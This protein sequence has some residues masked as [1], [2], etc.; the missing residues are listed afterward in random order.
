MLK[1]KRAGAVL[2]AGMM[3]VSMT[4]CGGDDSDSAESTTGA[5]VGN[6]TDSVEEGVSVPDNFENM[7][8]AM[9]ALAMENYYQGYPY[10]V[11]FADGSSR[12]S[13]WYSCALTSKLLNE[14]EDEGTI[15]VDDETMNQIVSGLYAS[16]QKGDLEFPEIRDGIAYAKY[17]DDGT[18]YV[19]SNSASDYVAGESS[20][21]QFSL[22]VT[23]CEATE[24]GYTLEA[25]LEDTDVGDNLGT[26]VF[27]ME[28]TQYSGGNSNPFAYSISSMY[29]ANDASAV[30]EETSDATEAGGDIESTDESADT[31]ETSESVDSSE[32]TEGDDA[33]QSDGSGTVTQDEALSMAQE[34]YGNEN[35]YTYQGVVYIDAYPYYSFTVESESLSISYVLVSESGTDVV[36]ANKNSDG[37]WSF[38]Q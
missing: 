26:Y 37:T 27:T 34:T 31:T 18:G 15:S 17:S 19:F 13:F 33:A 28:E 7:L 14:D 1:L 36:G 6:E 32:E 38:D 16:Y 23:S 29:D 35:T 20:L 22:T 2:L 5:V 25:D 4:A 11:Q 8:Y 10:Y 21:D 3:A 24:D 30:T 12:D 9:K